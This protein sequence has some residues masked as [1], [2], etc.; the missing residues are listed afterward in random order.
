[1][2]A[3]GIAVMGGRERKRR[4]DREG[5]A[6]KPG[7]DRVGASKSLDVRKQGV[8]VN[9]A[10][11]TIGD[12][13]LSCRLE[14]ERVLT[15]MFL[16]GCL[17]GRLP[18]C[19]RIRSRPLVEVCDER[20]ESLPDESTSWKPCSGS[21]ALKSGNDGGN[22]CKP[23]PRSPDSEPHQG[24]SHPGRVPGEKPMSFIECPL[25]GVGDENGGAEKDVHS[26]SGVGGER[27][28]VAGRR[29]VILRR[30]RV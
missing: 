12:R 3:D 19:N 6:E 24:V 25:L 1:M 13:L 21:A 23:H 4:S 8:S 26:I 7:P 20:A 5:D 14:R 11:S 22:W 30:W 2:R 16:A 18:H 27:R 10:P 29:P 9:V 15:E 28:R 17:E